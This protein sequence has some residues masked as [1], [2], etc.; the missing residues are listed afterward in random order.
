MYQPAD[1]AASGMLWSLHRGFNDLFER[2]RYR[3]MGL[4]DLVAASS[5]APVLVGFLAVRAR[6]ARAGAD[7]RT[8]LLPQCGRRPDAAARARPRRARAS[9]RPRSRFADVEQRDP[10]VIPADELDTIIDNIGIPNSWRSL[11]QGDIPN[12][13]ATDGEILISLNQE[14]ARPDRATTKSGFASGSTRS[15]RT[16]SSSSSRRTSRTRF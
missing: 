1:M 9:R 8:R 5:A 7:G 10:P 12:I 6:F 16:W 15:S 2:L 4:L 13:A 11:A 3:Y 14:R